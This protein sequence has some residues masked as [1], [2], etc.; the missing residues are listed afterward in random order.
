VGAAHHGGS[1]IAYS[2]T[3]RFDVRQLGNNP[4][5]FDLLLLDGARRARNQAPH[6][7]G[8]VEAVD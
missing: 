6:A 2:W 1:T 7:R 4:A 8:L 3:R 5:E